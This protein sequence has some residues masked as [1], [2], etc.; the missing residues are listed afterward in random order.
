MP[1][2]AITVRIDDHDWQVITTVAAAEGLEPTT[3]LAREARRAALAAELER[4][5]EGATE[6][7]DWLEATERESSE[8]WAGDG[9]E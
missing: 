4:V 1:K 5:E 8:L 9:E 3:W 6:N 2:R 7:Q